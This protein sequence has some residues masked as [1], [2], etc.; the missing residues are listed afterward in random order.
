M[1]YEVITRF[2][3]G[4]PLEI[5]RQLRQVIVAQADHFIYEGLLTSGE[6]ELLAQNA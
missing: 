5:V 3:S 4:E 1:L 2:E 6:W